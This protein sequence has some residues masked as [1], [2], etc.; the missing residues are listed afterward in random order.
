VC[1]VPQHLQQ[2]GAK[3][4]FDKTKAD[5]S[6]LSPQPLYISDVL[7]SV[8]HGITRDLPDVKADAIGCL[9]CSAQPVQQQGYCCVIYVS[10][11]A[12][13]TYHDKNT[14]GPF[15]GVVHTLYAIY[16]QKYYLVAVV[17]SD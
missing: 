10:C 15:G 4:A 12:S 5:F 2:L 7:Q 16:K 17:L 11:T 13:L 14:G 1:P 9:A 3:A 8:R 6:M